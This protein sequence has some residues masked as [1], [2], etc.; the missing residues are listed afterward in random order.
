LNL[1]GN[2]S[3]PT[4]EVYFNITTIW[5]IYALLFPTSLVFLYGIYRHIRAWRK[6]GKPKYLLDQPWKRLKGLFEYSFLHKGLLRDTRYRSV[7]LGHLLFFFGFFILF[8]ATLVVAIHEDLNIKIMTGDFYL[9]FQS[10]AVDVF[11]A[12]AMIGVGIVLYQRYLISE[13]LQPGKKE[14]AFVV[15]SFFIILVTGFFL[16]GM[17]IELTQDVWGNWSPVGK[18]FGLAS[19]QLLNQ[20][21]MQMV[22][23][24]TWWFHLV[25]VYVFIASLP[26]TKLIH[27]FT[28]PLN[29]YFRDLDQNW[30]KLES[31]DLESESTFGV[32]NLEDFTWKDLLSLDACTEC[33]RCEVNCPAFLSNKP[34]SP[35]EFILD[36]RDAMHTPK[37]KNQPSL[38]QENVNLIGPVIKEET[39]WSCTTCG[40]C[41]QQCPVM[42]E[43]VPMIMNMRRF[44]V[45]EQA[46]FPEDLQAMLRNLEARGHP[47]S[48]VNSSRTEW[49]QGLNIPS[50]EEIDDFEVL[51]WVGCAGAFNER[52]K[53][54]TRAVAKCLQRADVRFAILGTKERCSGDPARRIGHEYLFEMLARQNIETLTPHKTKKIVTS[55]PHCF[56]CLKNEYPQFG[57][58]FKVEHHSQFLAKLVS[59]GKLVPKQK[60]DDATVFHDPCY[61]G[62]YNKEF[63]APRQIIDSSINSDQIELDMSKENSLCCG[64][65]GGF[66]FMEETAGKRMSHTRTDQ[67]IESGANRVAVGCPFCMSMIDDAAKTKVPD[68]SLEVLDIAELLEESTRLQETISNN[69]ESD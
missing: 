43:P 13:R 16:E 55:C 19:S 9:Y 69:I 31:I 50:T 42:I 37:K 14:D 64:G 30:A 57:G 36:L 56:S 54:T 10:L 63:E 23:W 66:S 62:R 40:A 21:T 28:S 44:L 4:R 39:L 58:D 61:L 67:I 35:K 15:F 18:A 32:Q 46:E 51:Y 1:I 48:G 12:L 33:A 52:N 65:G 7:G 34:L 11:G 59:E 68:G 20:S 49:S 26:Y 60:S 5:P 47:Y 6:I 22:H 41:M 2:I 27:I 53:K 45:M 38:E 3:E 8:I 29:I 25:L 24:W 17:R